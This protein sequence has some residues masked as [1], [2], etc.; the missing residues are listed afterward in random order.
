[1]AEKKHF[2]QEILK[3]VNRK[4]PEK[5][6]DD[7]HERIA[8]VNKIID[9]AE[10]NINDKMIE[11]ENGIKEL[12][13]FETTEKNDIA[14]IDQKIVSDEKQMMDISKSSIENFNVMSS[15]I[16]GVL[17]VSD[18]VEVLRRELSEMRTKHAALINENAALVR[19]EMADLIENRVQA[20]PSRKEI[21][22]VKKELDLCV[23]GDGQKDLILRKNVQR[24]GKV[25][26]EL[27]GIKGRMTKAHVAKRKFSVVDI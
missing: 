9:A 17:K 11:L 25:E 3:A 2:F 26:R 8:R 12:R 14:G 15:K 22:E 1:M 19:R 7:F 18:N 13:E 20:M 5:P 6:K 4:S 23:K 21:E 24:L 10:K 27:K 16:E